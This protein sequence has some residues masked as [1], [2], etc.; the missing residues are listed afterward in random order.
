[1]DKD[2]L[3]FKGGNQAL[4]VRFGEKMISIRADVFSLKM[5][6]FSCNGNLSWVFDLLPDEI[7][8]LHS[9]LDLWIK[10]R[11]KA[12]ANQG[13]RR[14]CLDCTHWCVVPSDAAFSKIILGYDLGIGCDENHWVFRPRK[15]DENILRKYM[16]KAMDCADFS[17]RT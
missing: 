17:P 4:S 1:M 10:G 2:C 7:R 3:Q 5:I 13:E 8:E 11:E 14:I 15:D 16:Q 6:G 9:A 12:I